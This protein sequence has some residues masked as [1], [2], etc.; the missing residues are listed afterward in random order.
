MN[1]PTGPLTLDQAVAT[2]DG[3]KHWRLQVEN[4][5]RHGRS[6]SCTIWGLDRRVT[7]RARTPLMAATSALVKLREPKR[8]K[9][10]K[11]T[12]RLSVFS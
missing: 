11:E 8:K 2:M 10:T 12:P 4:S 9:R 1:E 3:F 7:A 5:A 6:Y